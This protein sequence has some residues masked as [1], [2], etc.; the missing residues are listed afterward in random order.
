MHLLL[1]SFLPLKKSL[2]AIAVLAMF[3]GCEELGSET[4]EALPEVEASSGATSVNRDV[5]RP[6]VFGVTENALW[7]G[8]PSLGGVWV[9]YPA[10]FDP[11]RVLIRNGVNGKTVIG[12]LFRRERD[13]PGPKLQLSSDAAVALG[14]VAGAPTEISVVVLRREEIVIDVPAAALAATSDTVTIPARRGALSIPAVTAPVAPVV[15]D[16]SA[17]SFTAIVEQTLDGVSTADAAVAPVEEAAASESAGDLFRLRKPY[18]QV[19]TFE[20]ESN[21]TALVDQLIAAGVQAQAQA[22]NPEAPTLW[23]VIS[24]PYEKRADRTAQLRIIKDLGFTQA[25][26]FK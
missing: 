1:G 18:I 7:D 6:D 2:A 22:D 3:A 17:A 5:E 25:F 20:T 8:R 24:G 21:A 4:D 9:A 16:T 10:N 13:N 26:F 19:G 14:I 23:R 15:T 11:E 12:A